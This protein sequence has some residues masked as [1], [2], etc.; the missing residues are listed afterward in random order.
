MSIELGG[1]AKTSKIINGDEE[2]LRHSN[3]C[4]A[5]AYY[6]AMVYEE[7]EKLGEM[8]DK[9]IKDIQFWL[10]NNGEVMEKNKGEISRISKGTIKTVYN[11]TF[12]EAIVDCQKYEMAETFIKLGNHDIPLY[13]TYIFSK[14][15]TCAGYSILNMIHQY[16]DEKITKDLY[17]EFLKNIFKEVGKEF[18]EITDLSEKSSFLARVRS[19]LKNMCPPC[20]F[21]KEEIQEDIK[22]YAKKQTWFNYGK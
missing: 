12:T 14:K 11:R 13:L 16:T 8:D 1:F 18:D 7:W 10:N 6:Y 2:E 21:S 17:I 15:E 9:L 5:A 22:E 3:I 19:H 20:Y 4:L